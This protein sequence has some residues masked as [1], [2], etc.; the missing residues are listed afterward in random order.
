VFTEMYVELSDETGVIKQNRILEYQIRKTKS[1]QIW[2][3][4]IHNAHSCPLGGLRERDRF[5]NFPSNPRASLDHLL[6]ILYDTVEKLR[7]LHPEL[8]FPEVDLNDLQNSINYLHFHF[9]HSHHVTKSVTAESHDHW[10]RFNMVLHAIESKIAPQADAFPNALLIFTWHDNA[11]YEIPDESYSEF[12]LN[13]EFGTAYSQYSQIGRHFTEMYWSGDDHLADE[14]VL[15]ARVISGDTLLW[16]GPS[17][18]QFWAMGHLLDLEKWFMAR[19]ERFERLGHRWGDPRLA[20]GQIPVARLRDSLHT[21]KE[22]SDFVQSLAGYNRV[23]NVW[24]K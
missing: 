5:D 24:L 1:A 16:F 2:A 4:A 20:L 17:R 7:A 3:Q 13:M 8:D 12:C 14:H 23:E 22:L 9:V 6:G 15:P 11:R 21:M 18:D 19:R 10:T